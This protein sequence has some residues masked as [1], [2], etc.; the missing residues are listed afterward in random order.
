MDSKQRSS[1]ALNK[2]DELFYERVTPD[3][4]ASRIAE[5]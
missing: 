4:E 2:I 5:I 1:Y 3:E